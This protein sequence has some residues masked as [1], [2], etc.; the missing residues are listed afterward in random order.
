[1]KRLHRRLLH[2]FNRWRTEIGKR[3]KLELYFIETIG[4]AWVATQSISMVKQVGPGYLGIFQQYGIYRVLSDGHMLLVGIFL[5]LFACLA[6][7]CT[8][9]ALYYKKKLNEVL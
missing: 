6:M 2:N 1:M 4:M 9:L 5:I 7:N 3:H 8:F